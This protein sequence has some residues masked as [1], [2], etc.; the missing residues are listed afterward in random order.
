[1]TVV[2]EALIRLGITFE[3]KSVV[4]RVNVARVS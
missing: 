3:R 1:M 4:A 2:S